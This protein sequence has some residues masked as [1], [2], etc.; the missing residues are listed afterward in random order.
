MVIVNLT[1]Q[2]FSLFIYLFI[3][4]FIYVFILKNAGFRDN[5]ADHQS[6]P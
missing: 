1:F 5:W 6:P 2:L 3:Y 4:V